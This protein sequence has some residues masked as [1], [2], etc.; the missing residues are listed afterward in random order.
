MFSL[1]KFG[2]SDYAKKTRFWVFYHENQK[3]TGFPLRTFYDNTRHLHEKNE[4]NLDSFGG[5][6]GCRLIAYIN[7]ITN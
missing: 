2:L 4:S 3:S 5:G 6:G 1:S 7:Y